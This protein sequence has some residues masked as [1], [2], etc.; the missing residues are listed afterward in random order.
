MK[1]TKNNIL[2]YKGYFGSIELSLEDNCLF[3]SLIGLENGA[4]TYEGNTLTELKD[5]FEETVD[6]YLEPCTECKIEP[7]KSLIYT[8]RKCRGASTNPAFAFSNPPH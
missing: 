2:T 8:A 7:Q 4:I 3:G 5:Q 1:G 6:T